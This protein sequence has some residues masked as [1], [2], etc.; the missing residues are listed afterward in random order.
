M[1]IVNIDLGHRI[2]KVPSDFI[3]M[4][5]GVSQRRQDSEPPT[6][7]FGF[8]YIGDSR[9]S[10]R[11]RSNSRPVLS[12]IG[13]VGTA[14]E[15]RNLGG[16]PEQLRAARRFL[17]SVGPTVGTNVYQNQHG[18]LQVQTALGPY[19]SDNFWWRREFADISVSVEAFVSCDANTSPNFAQICRAIV[20][21]Q[22]LEI[23]FTT[24]FHQQSVSEFP[25]LTEAAVR[26]LALWANP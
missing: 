6:I 9:T 10:F 18:M 16:V 1:S 22:G 7:I 8:A 24:T 3:T 2:L 25:A 21:I 14:N 19:V 4:S 23:T 26:L 13:N 20:E 5:P 15:V 11:A 12:G 17:N